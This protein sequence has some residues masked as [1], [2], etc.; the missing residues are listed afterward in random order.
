MGIEEG[1]AVGVEDGFGVG[2]GLATQVIDQEPDN[3]FKEAVLTC[4]VPPLYE[5][6][7]LPQYTSAPVLPLPPL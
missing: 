4:A 5:P 7:P 6:P 2:A 1:F 3:V